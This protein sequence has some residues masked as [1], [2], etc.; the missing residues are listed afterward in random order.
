MGPYDL[1]RQRMVSE[2]LIDRGIRDARVLKA[3]GKVPR[4]LFVDGSL[5][6]Q[7][8]DDCALS[9]EEGQTISQPYM[10]AYMTEQLGLKGAEKIL[11][12]GTGSGY[13]AAVLSH[14]VREIFSI[15]RMERLVQKARNLLNQVGCQNI[16]VKVKNGTLGWAEEAPFDAILVTAGSPHVPKP[17]LEQLKPAGRMIIP[18]GDR[19]SQVLHRIS[20][21]PSGV[22]DQA[23]SGCVF[24]PLIG[25]YAW[26]DRSVL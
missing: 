22:L 1:A 7:A 19:R 14:L 24:V 9:I 26:K 17:L 21:T 5:R 23:L 3:M 15:E 25:A 18:I 12:I 4:H 11:E 20:M 6:N 2:Q 16:R 13:Q 10:V 8:Y